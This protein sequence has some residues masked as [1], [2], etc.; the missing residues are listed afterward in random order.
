MDYLDRKSVD[1]RDHS[2]YFGEAVSPTAVALTALGKKVEARDMMDVIAVEDRYQDGCIEECLHSLF[3]Q[4]LQ[5]AFG[6]DL[7]EHVVSC[8][9]G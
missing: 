7:A 9:G 1:Y 6:P 4:V 3:A 5:V 8:R 2:Q